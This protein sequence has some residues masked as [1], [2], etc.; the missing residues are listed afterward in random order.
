MCPRYCGTGPFTDEEL[1]S[2]QPGAEVIWRALYSG[3]L[4]W[5]MIQLLIDVFPDGIIAYLYGPDSARVRGIVMLNML[6]MNQHL[7]ELQ[8]EVAEWRVNVF[9]FWL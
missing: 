1:A 8:L 6:T 3:Y 4:Q 7:M 9:I 5:H 2:R